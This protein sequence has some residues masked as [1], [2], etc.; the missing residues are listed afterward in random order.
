[1]SAWNFRGENIQVNTPIASVRPVMVTASTVIAYAMYA[2][3][4]ETAEKFHTRHLIYTIPMVL[5]GIFRYLYLIH[6]KK[7]GGAPDEL[8]FKDKPLLVNTVL[9]A[10]SVVAIIYIW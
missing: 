10:V 3:S 5:F 8:L 6:V 2:I 1:M 9:W 4:P 7:L